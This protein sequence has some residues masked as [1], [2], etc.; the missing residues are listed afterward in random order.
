MIDDDDYYNSLIYLLKLRYNIPLLVSVA[1]AVAA[2]PDDDDNNRI[3]LVE[4]FVLFSCC[5]LL[6]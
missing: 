2:P 6:G 5:K 3:Y 4:C 1:G